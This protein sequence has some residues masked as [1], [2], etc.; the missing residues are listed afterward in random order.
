MIRE[1]LTELERISWLWKG[2][3]VTTEHGE[4]KIDAIDM[5]ETGEYVAAVIVHQE[6]FLLP[7]TQLELTSEG[8]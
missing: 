5:N 1:F 2:S 8:I 3:A 4:G 6:R 7:M